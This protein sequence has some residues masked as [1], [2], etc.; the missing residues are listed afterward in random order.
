MSANTP[1]GWSA[2]P[3]NLSGD[4]IRVVAIHVFTLRKADLTSAMVTV[5]TGVPQAVGAGVIIPRS[6]PAISSSG[7]HA[8]LPAILQCFTL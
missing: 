5:S 3:E 6:K 1:A 7:R 8:L 2:G 4:S